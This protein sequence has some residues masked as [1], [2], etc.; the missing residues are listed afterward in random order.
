M[1]DPT[2]PQINPAD[3]VENDW[4]TLY[5]NVKEVIPGNAP[6]PL[7][8]LVTIQYFVDVDHAGDKVI[9]SSRTGYVYFINSTPIGVYSKKPGSVEGVTFRSEFMAMKT[10]VEA[11]RALR[12]KLQMMGVLIDGPT[13]LYGDN[14]SVL[15]NMRTPES[16]LKKR[17]NS[18]AYHFIREC[19]AMGELLMGYI[20]I[21]DNLAGL[22][23]KAI[24]V[25]EKRDGLLRGLMRDV[26]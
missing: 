17:S 19:V 3:F 7:G 14:L 6:E 22:M 5:G 1:F 13:Y 20:W 15:H 12:Y 23:A 2:Q 9:R 18:I 8:E 4:S 25:G 24:A 10:T 11:N 21:K 16:M 26:K